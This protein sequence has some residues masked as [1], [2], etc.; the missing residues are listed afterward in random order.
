[1]DGC[2]CIFTVARWLAGTQRDACALAHREPEETEAEEVAAETAGFGG[3]GAGFGAPA[4]DVGAYAVIVRFWGIGR[5]VSV[6][7]SSQYSAPA[8][9]A[10]TVATWLPVSQTGHYV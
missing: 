4:A 7:L 3:G 1:M 5:L 9:L 2:D 6:M 8:S 10:R